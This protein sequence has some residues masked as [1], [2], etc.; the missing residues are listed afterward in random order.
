ME[1]WLA[2]NIPVLPDS[3][4]TVDDPSECPACGAKARMGDGACICCLLRTG[5]DDEAGSELQSWDQTLCE[6]TIFDGDW[7]RGDRSVAEQIGDNA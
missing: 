3:A 6:I 5:L 7:R 2:T 1:N 4:S